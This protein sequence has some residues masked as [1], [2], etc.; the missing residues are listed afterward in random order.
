[1][2]WN[3]LWRNLLGHPIRSL[4][5]VLSVMVAVFLVSV[6]HAVVSGLDR[7]IDAAASNRLLVQSAVSLFVNLPLGYQQKLAGVPGVEAICKWQYFGGKYEQDKGGYFAQFGIDSATFL[8]SYPEISIVDGSYEE[9][10][11]GRT[12]CLVGTELAE[13]YDWKVGQTV[14][15]TGSLFQR[16]DEKPWEFTIAGIYT[17]NSAAVDKQTLWFHF[18]YL[19][20]S[21]EQGGAS[22]PR[23]AG[24]YMLRIEKGAD[25]VAVQ[26][27]QRSVRKT[28]IPCADGLTRGEQ[29]LQPVLDGVAA[30]AHEFSARL[31][32]QGLALGILLAQHTRT[33]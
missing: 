9:F 4:L 3:L 30:I 29:H 7:T 10:A 31:E 14:P 19:H 15:I 27:T 26:R 13:K 28:A 21:L 18:D 5:T 1:M 23:G 20:E 11:K 33:L 17:S 24:V 12:A 25:P 8:N 16:T 22:G 32:D 6:L 2:P